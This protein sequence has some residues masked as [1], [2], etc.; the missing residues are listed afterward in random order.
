MTTL[1]LNKIMLCGR[2]TAAPEM[3]MTKDGE[4]L[5]CTFSVAVN[6]QYESKDGTKADF[7][8]CIASE[9]T[10][11]VICKYFGKGDPIY[12]EGS[13]RLNSW[14]TENGV[15]RSSCTVD[16]GEFRFVESKGNTSSNE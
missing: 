14:T 13:V 11:E 8:D 1:N 9:K 4:K 7:F 16:V 2:L 3:K 15:K 10:G 5:F 6:R 12:V